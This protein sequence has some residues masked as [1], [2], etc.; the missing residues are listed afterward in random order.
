MSSFHHKLYN[1]FPSQ[2]TPGELKFALK[3]EGV[4]NSLPHPEYR[5]LVVE[6]LMVA[7]LVATSSSRPSFG[8]K[9]LVVEHIIDHAQRLFLQDQVLGGWFC[10][11]VVRS[12]IRSRR[13]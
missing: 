8:D 4:L 13:L 5:Q 2:M 12:N 9:V 11:D 3:V 10:V 6:A 1:Y 7:G